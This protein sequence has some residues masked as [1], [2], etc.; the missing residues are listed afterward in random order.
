MSNPGTRIAIVDDDP[1]VRKA[2]ARLLSAC[3]FHPQTYPSARLF[4]QSLSDGPP[5]CLVLDLQMPEMTG[6]ELQNELA[7]SGI[8]IPVVVITAHDE[9]RIRQ[10]CESAGAID[11]LCK[12]LNQRTL[13]AAI[14]NAIG[15]R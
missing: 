8:K 7:R 14:N 11:F 10:E 1:G 13:I 15:A 5:D 6:L 12:P 4:L 9:R 2:L 3:S